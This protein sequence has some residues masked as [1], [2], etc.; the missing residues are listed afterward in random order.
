VVT[1]LQVPLVDECIICLECIGVEVAT[2][3]CFCRFHP[4]CIASWYAT[5]Q[6]TGCPTHSH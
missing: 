2:L 3:D 4:H 1:Q 5:K 6:A